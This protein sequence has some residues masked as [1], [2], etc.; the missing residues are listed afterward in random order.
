M[1]FWPRLSLKTRRCR[2]DGNGRELHWHESFDPEDC[3]MCSRNRD[4]L[5]VSVRL[6]GSPRF[7]LRVGEGQ[8]CP[9]DW[10]SAPALSC[11]LAPTCSPCSTQLRRWSC[12]TCSWN[13]DNSRQKQRPG[14]VSPPPRC[15][16]HE[17][18]AAHTTSPT[19]INDFC[20][21]QTYQ[22]G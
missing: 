18:Q 6:P 22:H 9:R 5:S 3:R 20:E 12:C 17:P 7:D 11:M 1:A 14:R 15:R 10:P 21:G 2:A 19:I 13:F 16:H 4:I 8:S